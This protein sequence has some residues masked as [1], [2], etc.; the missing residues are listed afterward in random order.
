VT[1]LRVTGEPTGIVRIPEKI[2]EDCNTEGIE[3]ISGCIQII[4]SVCD[5]AERHSDK[6]KVVAQ[7][8]ANPYVL[9]LV[10]Y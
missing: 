7:S 1:V 3:S 2:D 6:L 9:S 4:Y 5:N 10:K 8:D